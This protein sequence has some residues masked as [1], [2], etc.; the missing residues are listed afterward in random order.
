MLI[1]RQLL[2]EVITGGPST[3]QANNKQP[4]FCCNCYS[5]EKQKIFDCLFIECSNEMKHGSFFE[6]E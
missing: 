4:F 6:E 3:V 2:P 5:L 1:R